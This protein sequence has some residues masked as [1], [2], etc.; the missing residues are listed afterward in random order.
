LGLSPEEM[1]FYDALA[2]NDSAAEAMGNDKL[3][4]VAHELLENLR[5]N[6][7]VD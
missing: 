5:K 7:T 2:E 3:R 6:V 1:A 4:I